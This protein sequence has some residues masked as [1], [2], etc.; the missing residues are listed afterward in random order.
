[1][2]VWS[3]SRNLWA[4][5]LISILILVSSILFRDF[6][7]PECTQ[8]VDGPFSVQVLINCDS[9]QIVQDS[10]TPS[11]L[12]NAE[13]SYQDRPLYTLT[14][15]IISKPLRVLSDSSEIYR[16]TKNEPITFYYANYLAFILIN[17]LL[18]IFIVKQSINLV[19]R[20]LP[21]MASK[22]QLLFLATTLVVLVANN[23][24]KGFVWTPHTQL[25]NLL[26]VIYS[27]NLWLEVEESGHHRVKITHF[28]VLGLLLFFYPMF[29]LLYLIPLLRNFK[30]HILPTIVSISPYLIYPALLRLLGGKYRNAAIEDFDGFVWVFRTLDQPGLVLEKIRL[31][32][33]SFLELQILY[34]ALAL[35]VLIIL[36][37]RARL[38]REGWRYL[39]F[40]GAFGTFVFLMG[41]SGPRL[42]FPILACLILYLCIFQI[43]IGKVHEAMLTQVLVSGFSL[44]IFFFTQGPLT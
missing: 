31:F 43:R 37:H 1:M 19:N 18:L 27:I 4:F 28:F 26:L 33:S 29:I 8:K 13:T 5:G 40:I 12:W 9:A 39:I 23:V 3:Q 20:I 41:Y 21:G 35:L 38:L 30:S 25:F 10:Q 14:G 6:Q 7:A 15:Y 32:T 36:K 17:F 11:R 2:K 44:G 24:V 22:G 16:N 34:M 42:A